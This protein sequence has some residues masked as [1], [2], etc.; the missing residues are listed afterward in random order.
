VSCGWNAGIAALRPG[1]ECDNCGDDEFMCSECGSD[2][3][4][5][6][7]PATQQVGQFIDPT[8]WDISEGGRR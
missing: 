2:E 3:G 1:D 7:L 8:V 5:E 6:H 4:C